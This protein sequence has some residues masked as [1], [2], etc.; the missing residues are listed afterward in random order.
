[1]VALNVRIAILIAPGDIYGLQF[2]ALVQTGHTLGPPLMVFA[3]LRKVL[4]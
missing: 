1:M 3:L 4:I 2:S